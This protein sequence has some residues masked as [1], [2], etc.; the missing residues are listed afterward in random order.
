[1]TLSAT[2]GRTVGRPAGVIAVVALALAAP[3]GAA[4]AREEKG[5]TF[6]APGTTLPPAPDS[7]AIG[8]PPT[9]AAPQSSARSG[10]SRTSIRAPAP[11]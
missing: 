11:P 7:H 4:P 10:S 3:A 2:L 5:Q 8:T 9:D 1:M 6:Q